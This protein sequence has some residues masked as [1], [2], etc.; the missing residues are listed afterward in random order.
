MNEGYQLIKKVSVW[1]IIVNLVL[2]AFKLLAGILARSSAMVSDSIHSASDVMTTFVVIAG[3]KMAGKEA[4]ED[5][6]YGHERMESIAGIILAMILGVTG[7]MIGYA[8]VRKIMLGIE[9]TLEVPGS[10]A[11][12]AALV[13]IGLKEAMFWITR[14]AAKKTESSALMADAWHHRSDALSSVG[15][16]IGIGGAMLGFPILDPIASLVI[17]LFILKAAYDVL[18]DGIS[19]VVDKSIDKSTE[20]PIRESVLGVSGVLRID[21]LKSRIFGNKIFLDIEIG[22]DAFM[23]LE[24]SHDIAEKVHDHI[25]QQYSSV[26]HCNVH[27]N[28][29]YKEDSL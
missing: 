14:H 19:R 29:V 21:S 15:S 24:D 2:S 20:D 9:G 23:K 6:P 12:V 5:H 26:K 18:K 13:S 28:P 3:V 1:S 4:D 27:V 8:G 25:E 10:L 7:V 11:L 22:C 17:C 16:F